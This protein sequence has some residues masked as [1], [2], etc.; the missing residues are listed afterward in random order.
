[1]KHAKKMPGGGKI[2]Q[3]AAIAMAM[4]KA[5]KKPK[6]MKKGGK[7]PDLTG[8]GKVTKADILKGRGVKVK[9]KD[10]MKVKGIGLKKAKAGMKYKSAGKGMKYGK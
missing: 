7:F 5:G 3:Q 10:G 9:G 8:D 6:S 4:K 2:A 1:M